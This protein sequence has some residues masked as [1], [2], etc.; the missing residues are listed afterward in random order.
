[1]LQSK[2]AVQGNLDPMLLITGGESL[3][4]ETKRLLDILGQGPY[5]FNLG[6]GI[7][8]QGDPANV[9]KMLRV[10]RG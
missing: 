9:E 6:H 8:P 7:T 2:V 5:I 10:I 4:R 1:V 3:E